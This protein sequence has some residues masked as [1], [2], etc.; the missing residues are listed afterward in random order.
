MVKS[1]LKT[2]VLVMASAVIFGCA[3]QQP[4]AVF[5][6]HDLNPKLQSGEYVQKV[7]NF[8]L[9]LDGSGSMSGPELSTMKEIASRMNQTIPDMDLMAGVRRFGQGDYGSGPETALLYGVEPYAKA[10]VEG[11]IRTLR[12]GNGGSP[13]GAAIQAAGEDLKSVQGDIALIVISDGQEMDNTPVTA[14]MK[15]KTTYCDRLCIYT[16]AVGND[17]DGKVILER[18]ALAGKCGFATDAGSLSSPEG[19]ADFVEKVFLKK[20]VKPVEPPK[21]VPPKKVVPV[22]P[23]D[24]DGDGITDDKDKCPGTP[25]GAP[26][27]ADGC[28]EINNVEF[29]T[30]KWDIKPGFES[31]LNQVA[32]IMKKNPWLKME[33][34]GHTDIRGTARHNQALSENRANA[35]M[36]YLVNQGISGN[37][38]STEA[39]SYNK[40][41]ATN[42]TVE[43]MARNRRA[44]IMAVR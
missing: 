22:K 21:P 4:M 30:D 41:I 24:S 16:V 3:A 18:V 38:L 27:N 6:A 12:N 1:V 25:M 17:P 28:W 8:M 44:E 7:D 42:N 34:H 33:V 36:K 43:G 31:V 19:M 26:V 29:D 32:A 13:L 2:L 10:G 11:A 20:F 37:R 15:M 40:P 14:A 39:F 9:I 23:K 35:V 5:K